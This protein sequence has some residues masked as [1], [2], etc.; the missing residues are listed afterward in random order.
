MPL[1]RIQCRTRRNATSK[2]SKQ[3]LK[4]GQRCQ[5]RTQANTV[6]FALTAASLH[7]TSSAYAYVNGRLCRTSATAERTP[8]VSTASTA[9]QV[10]IPPQPLPAFPLPSHTLP[11]QTQSALPTPPMSPLLM[12][13][14]GPVTPL[15]SPDV[16]L[17]LA[18]LALLTNCAHVLAATTNVVMSLAP[19]VQVAS[20]CAN[21]MARL[22]NEIASGLDDAA[23]VTAICTLLTNC[24]RLMAATT[25]L[26]ISL[27]PTVPIMPRLHVQIA[28]QCANEMARL[29]NELA[30]AHSTAQR[31]APMSW[32]ISG[33]WG[34][35][36]GRSSPT[37]VSVS[38][39][40]FAWRS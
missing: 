38:S 5:E 27:A 28:T 18:V 35:R 24:D 22:A 9:A 40:P 4:N 20:H 30:S 23:M 19:A 31:R 33:R 29:A 25:S 6:L 13:A 16:E 1:H 11:S 21:K 34:W 32:P 7:R 12:P 15:A 2:S 3:N 17:A 39:A 37:P 26:A 10:S 36:S 8:R 14:A